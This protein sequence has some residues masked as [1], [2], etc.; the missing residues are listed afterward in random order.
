M[1]NSRWG[2]FPRW[3]SD[4]LRKFPA[5][6]E[7][8]AHMAALRVYL[9][10]ALV[11]DFD[12]REASISWSDL[13]EQTG[14]S[15]PMVLKGIAAAEKAELISI[16]KSSHR[17]SYRLLR[18]SDDEIAFIQVP[19]LELRSALPSFPARG[20]HALDTLKLYITLLAVRFRNSDKAV[21]S[22]KKIWLR[23]GIQPGRVRAAI[24]V[25]IERH[26]IHVQ[27]AESI[28]VGG[29]PYNEYILLGFNIRPAVQ[30]LPSATTTPAMELG[31]TPTP[32]KLNNDILSFQPS[33][34]D[35]NDIPF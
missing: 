23:T 28:G 9:A 29:H 13:Q 26:L 31:G 2:S 20:F 11:A 32:I 16:D 18:E 24:D 34:G 12:T 8:G 22:H 35:P 19:L 30:T 15:R 3:V 10:L 33:R 7:A 27:R 14:L 17:H 4:A 25:L 6:P 5:G 1:I 21:I